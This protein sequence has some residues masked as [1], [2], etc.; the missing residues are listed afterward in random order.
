MS[1]FDAVAAARGDRPFDLLIRNVRLVNV[2]TAEILPSDIGIVGNL[3]AAVA[4]ANTLG[5]A[6]NVIEGGG[7]YATPGFIDGHV[8]NESSMVTPAEWARVIVPKGTTTVCTDPHEIGNVLGL[9]GIRYMLQASEGLPLRYYV[10]G[11]SC[12]P[13][14]PS[15]E[16]AGA[17]IQAAEMAELLS[18]D[19]VIA[20]AEAMDYMGLITQTGNITPIVEKGHEFG[21]AIQGHAPGVVGPHLQAYLAA[22]GPRGSDHESMMPDEMLEKVRAGMLLFARVSVYMDTSP[23]LVGAMQQVNDSRLFGFCTDDVFPHDLLREGHLDFGLRRI[24]SHG[25]DPVRAIQMAT[26]NVANYYGLHG[27]GAIGPGYLADVLLLDDLEAISVTDV[28]VDGRHVVAGGEWQ[29]PLEQ[30]IP[31]LLDNTVRLP[32]LD[33]ADFWPTLDAPDGPMQVNAIDMSQFLTSLKQLELEVSDDR[34]RLPLPDD[35]CIASV[36]PR[37]GQGTTPSLAFLSGY[38]LQRGAVASTV[39][40]DSHNLVIIGKDPASMLAAA[41]AIAEMQGGFVAVDGDETI[42]ALPLPIAGLMSPDSM[43]DVAAQLQAF[44]AA[45]TQLGLPPMIPLTLIILA[46]PVYP[47]IRLSDKG[48]VDVATQQ[49]IPIAAG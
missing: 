27:H 18:W 25:V 19:R 35:I 28:I 42:A 10:A 11:S 39:A 34:V 6:E 20:V 46:L 33:E 30:P 15:V 21:V 9:P 48:M 13:A 37:H 47:M 4:P 32:K 40:H 43:A 3:I 17:T 31:P 26:I 16:T 23:S 7:R 5:P 14:V 45:V 1:R 12:V 38:G 49:L 24:I 8:H 22:T 29:V 41:R 44:A 2:F 36:V